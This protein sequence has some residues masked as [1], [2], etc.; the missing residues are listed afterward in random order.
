MSG[1]RMAGFLFAC[2]VTALC[3]PALAQFQWPFGKDQSSKPPRE[4]TEAEKKAAAEEAAEVAAVANK[5]YTRP[6]KVPLP[7]GEAVALSGP[8]AVVKL[9]GV[10]SPGMGELLHSAIRRAEAE[11]AQAVLIEIDTPGGLVSTTQKMVQAILPSKVAVIVFVSPSGAHAASAG[12]FITLAGHIAAMAPATR[13]GAAHPVTGGGKDPEAD[14]GKHMG[15]K[16]ENDLVAMVEGIAETRGRN[17]EW[18]TDAVKYSVSITAKRALEIGVIDIV[19]ID[20]DD[21]LEQLDGRELM[22]AKKKVKL[23]TSNVKI[24]EYTPTLRQTIL[25]NLASPGIAMLLGLLGVIGIMVEIYH[26]GV[27]APG[28]MGVLCIILSLIAMDQLPVSLGAALLTLAGIGLLVTEMYT[29][30]YGVFGLLGTIGLTVGLLLLF[31]PTDP[32]F[33]MDPGFRL[34]VIDV[35]PVV[36]TMVALVSYVSFYVVK[37][38]AAEIT[39]GQEALVGMVGS[40]LEDLEGEGMVLVDGEYWRARVSEPVA[41]DAQVEVVSVDGLWLVVRSR[42]A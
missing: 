6:E 3:G 2:G 38:Q 34:T 18:A 25:A 35:L 1:G 41:K 11:G 36:I 31:D 5:A 24:V 32:E 15:R 10:V 12:T 40:A 21:L 29:P 7:E 16:V 22:V 14:G 37:A 8:V 42:R 17:K 20:R 9:G 13:I 39:T 30:T 27:V 28:V 23:Q 33:A 26:P 4:K 19:A